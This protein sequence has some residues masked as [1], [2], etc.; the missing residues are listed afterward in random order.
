MSALATSILIALLLTASLTL[1]A[2]VV[3]IL[4]MPRPDRQGDAF[5][6]QPFRQPW[7]ATRCGN[8]DLRNCVSPVP[9]GEARPAAGRMYAM[10]P[11]A[12]VRR[13]PRFF[14]RGL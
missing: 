5:L 13:L 14:G 10:P 8:E 1:L 4:F 6:D 3:G 2:A 9:S 7:A 11:A 12:T